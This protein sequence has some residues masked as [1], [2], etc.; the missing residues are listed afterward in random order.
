M[1]SDTV[2]F[3]RDLPHNLVASFKATLEE[4]IHAD[5]LLHVLD[6][7]HPH[8]EQQFKSVH[9]VLGDIGVRV[10]KASAQDKPELLLLNKI[11]T[12][13]GEA[14][15]PLWRALHPNAI[16]I[17]AKAGLGL[18]Q[19]SKAV[20]DF[21]RGQR[22]DVTLQVDVRDGKLISFIESHTLVRAREIDDTTMRIAVTVGKQ[23]LADLR[24]NE[25]VVILD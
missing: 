2:G 1:L 11:D 16:A 8:A 21:V 25:G 9:E 15:M 5:L 12:P 22:S 19:L 18:D 10:G 24:R 3:V 4:A 13:E 20:L 23:T 7:G 14:A 17:S 6:V